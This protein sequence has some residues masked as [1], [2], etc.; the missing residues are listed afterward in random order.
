MYPFG[1]WVVVHEQASITYAGRT[2]RV[3]GNEVT[4]DQQDYINA[5][6]S[7]LPVK[8]VKDLA[9][10]EECNVDEVADFQSSVGD[11]HWVISQTRVDHAVD[12]SRYQ[13]RQKQ[14]TYG[15][16]LD[17]GRT[18]R[19]VRNSRFRNP[20]EAYSETNPRSMD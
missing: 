15:D 4:L 7:D 16:Y 1:E 9:K 11:L 19:E 3:S 5:R 2:I 12:T 14:P 18:V 20:S 17:L 13:K 10:E 6:M 8:K